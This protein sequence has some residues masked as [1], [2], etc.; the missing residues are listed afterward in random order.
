MI[1]FTIQKL[2]ATKRPAAEKNVRKSLLVC[3]TTFA[4][5]AEP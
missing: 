2:L 1:Q 4:I 5:R 3:F